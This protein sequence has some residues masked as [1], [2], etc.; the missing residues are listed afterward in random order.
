MALAKLKE[1]L[2]RALQEHHLSHTGCSTASGSG[3]CSPSSSTFST[4][5]LVLRCEAKGCVEDQGIASSCVPTD[6]IRF[7]AIQ[8]AP[9]ST[10]EANRDFPFSGVCLR[11]FRG[12]LLDD[13]SEDLQLALAY[14]PK[15]RGSVEG[16][17][18]GGSAALDGASP[19]SPCQF[20]TKQLV[21]VMKPQGF[22][23]MRATSS[24]S[25][26]ALPEGLC[27]PYDCLRQGAP[28]S[29]DDVGLL[30]FLLRSRNYLSWC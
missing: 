17:K 11:P 3:D 4:P 24:L 25:K 27:T 20:S 6:E 26:V 7:R 9:K 8:S 16:V 30:V 12:N 29:G 15:H 23:E 1:E 14:N 28:S 2:G 5:R 22:G 21:D 10:I 18:L 19:R 13:L